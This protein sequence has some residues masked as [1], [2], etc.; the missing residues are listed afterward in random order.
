VLAVGDGA[1][2]F[3]T[4]L[5]EVFPETKIQR[6]RFH[7]IANVLSA[8]PKSA[9]PGATKALA[10]IWNAEDKQH[11]RTAVTAFA[12]LYGVKWPKATA[13]ITEDV[14]ELLAFYDYPAEHW[15]HDHASRNG[16][17]LIILGA[18]TLLIMQII[19]EFGPLWLVAMAAPAIL[20]GPY[21][22]G[23]VSTL[24]IGGLLAGNIRMTDTKTVLTVV[25]VMISAS[26]MLKTTS[27]IA[28]AIAAQVILALLIGIAGIHAGAALHDAVPSAV[29]AGVASGAGTISWI[30]FLPFALTFG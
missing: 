26:V 19:L 7:K 21:W 6:C 23:L 3:W 9:H 17:R 12:D 10:E 24:G 29:R 5:G 15:I 8:L 18:L 16:L 25:G 22:A 2:G 1:L 30:G 14:E 27:S 11:A 4:A 28:A 13:K 20:F